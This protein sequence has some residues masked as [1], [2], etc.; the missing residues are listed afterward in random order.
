[1]ILSCDPTALEKFW[2]VEYAPE[3]IQTEA[4]RYP[5]LERIRSLLGGEVQV[6]AV[7]IPLDCTDGFGEAYFGRPEAL[8][9]A[10]ARTA[11]SAWSFVPPETHQRFESELSRDLESGAWD[12]RHGHLRNQEFFD[13]SLQLMVSTTRT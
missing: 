4:R 10:G 12:A 13:G 1:M 5:P 2:L 9:D 11:N 7:P 8:L 6:H 3:V